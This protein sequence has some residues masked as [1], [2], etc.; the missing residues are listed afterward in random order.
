MISIYDPDLRI[1]TSVDTGQQAQSTL[2]LNILIELR[3]H[4]MY[5]QTQSMGAINSDPEQLRMDVVGDVLPKD[6]QTLINT[7]TN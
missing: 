4:T 2:M 1:F 6:G 3:V 5:L 7:N